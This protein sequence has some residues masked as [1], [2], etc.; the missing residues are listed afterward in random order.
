MTADAQVSL[1]W[2]AAA[3]FVLGFPLLVWHGRRVGHPASVAT[4]RAA[5][6]AFALAFPPLMFLVS[7]RFGRIWGYGF[8]AAVV[9]P[10]LIGRRTRRGTPPAV[11]DAP[12]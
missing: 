4:R 8:A 2:L 11:D 9:I 12:P 7:M 5:V 3:A 10:V 1:A 6:G